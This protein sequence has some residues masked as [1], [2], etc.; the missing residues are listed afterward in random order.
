MV[1]A[2]SSLI[3][4]ELGGNEGS[5]W[6]ETVAGVNGSLYGILPLHARR[7]VEFN[8][9]DN[10]MTPIGPDFGGGWKWWGGAMTDSGVNSH[11]FL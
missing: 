1:S 10:S 6:S 2:I 4:E 7:V 11:V 9:L 3:G 8:P 5:K